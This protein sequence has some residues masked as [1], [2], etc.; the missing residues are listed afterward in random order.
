MKLK[1]IARR[2][3]GALMAGTLMVSML[4]MTAFAEETTTTKTHGSVAG[5]TT[6]EGDILTFS[7]YLIMDQN[8]YVPNVTFEYDIVAGSAVEA[9]ESTPAVKA[10]IGTPSVVDTVFTA[11]DTT[12]TDVA[13]K[14]FTLEEKKKYAEKA[15]KVDL[16]GVTFTEPGIYRY[17]ITEKTDILPSGI[18]N[19][20][21]TVYLDV[22]VVNDV[23]TNALSIEGYIFHKS[24]EVAGNNGNFASS[25]EKITGIVNNYTTT[26]LSLKK[27][28]TGN[29]GNRDEYF[30][31]TI[32][33]GNAVP[34][35]KFDVSG[36]KA[37]NP[38]TVEANEKGSI[39]IDVSLKHGDEVLVKGLTDTTTFVIT[40]NIQ[41]AEGYTTTNTIN[42]AE[43]ADGKT[44]GEPTAIS[45]THAVTFINNRAVTTPTGLILNIAPYILM[46][47]LAGILAFFFLRRRKSEF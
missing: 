26:D 24:T 43:G 35:T 45:A 27:E 7:K 8:A 12:S 36:G 19:V 40:E 46:V 5:A 16:S 3:A 31:F 10:G 22:Y 37:E 15:V 38:D 32:T 29:Q 17:V 30:S 47:A 33:I 18:S 42:T 4:G 34:G 11:S 1:K 25:D 14:S 13:G 20:D 41:A 44:T 9:T 6:G 28:V 23:N 39:D 21:N 2:L